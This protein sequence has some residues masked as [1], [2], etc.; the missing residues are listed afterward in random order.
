VKTPPMLIWSI[1]TS[2]RRKVTWICTIP[3]IPAR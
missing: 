2:E 3:R 1:T